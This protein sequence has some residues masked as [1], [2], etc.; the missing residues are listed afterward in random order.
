MLL[1]LSLVALRYVD[2]AR[3]GERARWFVRLAFPAAAM[4]LPAAFFL[5][6]LDPAATEPHALI[7]LAYGVAVLLVVAMVTLGTG[8]VRHDRASDR[9]PAHEDATAH[10]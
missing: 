4:L 8:L 2:E 3:L 6:V 7:L 1:V 5:S 10:R 9:D